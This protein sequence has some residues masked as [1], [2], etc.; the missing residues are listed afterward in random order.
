M[1]DTTPIRDLFVSDVTRDIPPVVYFHEQSPEKLAAEVGE[2]IITGGWPEDHPNHRRVPEG[3]HEQYVRL[4]N[5]IAAELDRP[6]GPDLPTIWISGFFGSGKSIFSKLLGLALDGIPLP[7]GTS[8]AEAWLRRDTSPRASELRDAWTALRRKIDPIAVVFDVGSVA[9]DNEQVHSVAVRQVQRRLGYCPTE[10][11]VADFELTLERDGHWTRF[12]QVAQETLGEPW[13]QIK[14]RDFAEEDFSL[15]MSRLFPDYY[16]DPMAWFTSRAGT[17]LRNESPEEAVR[18]ISDM[19]RLRRPNATLFLVV[20]EVSQ[21]V[22]SSKDR[23]DRLRAFATALGAGLKGRVW[24]LAL[25]QQ[26]LDE[27]ADQSFLIW[28]KDRF[29]PKLRVHLA[30]TN[31]RDVVHKRLLHKTPAAEAELRARFE[32]HRT[33]LKLFAYGCESVTIEDL[34]EVYPLLPGHIDLL[35]QITSAMR[36]RSRRVQGDDQA[37]RGLLQMLGELFRAQR[38]ADL[39]VGH[40]ISL[41]RIYEVQHSALDSDIQASMA[42]ILNQCAEEDGLLIR[43]AK[44]VALLELIQDVL[45]TDAKLVSQCLYDRLDRGNQVTEITEALETLRRRNLLGYSEKT[46]YKIQSSAGEEWERERADIPVPRETIGDGIKQALEILLA[47]PHQPRLQGRPFPWAGLLSDGRSH[48][49]SRFGDQ[50]SDAVIQ[51]DFRFI[52]TEERAESLWVKRSA[53]S[54][55]E[56]RILWVCGDTD[57]LWNQVRE[58]ARSRGMLSKFTPRRES[59]NAARKILLEQEKV[60]EE[61]LASSVQARVAATWM[62]GHLYFR[63]RSL[64]PGDLGGGFASALEAVGTRLL[65]ELYPHFV[66][67]DLQPGELLHLLETD[68]TGPSPKLMTGELG[69]LE[70]DHGRYEP[71]CGGAVPKRVQDFIEAEGGLGGTALLTHFGRPPYGYT[72]NVVK[73]CV[74]GLLRGNKLRIQPE[75]TPE[76]TAVRDA[77]VRDLFEKDRS[78]RRANVFPSGEDD[79]GYPVRARICK[80]FEKHLRTEVN[81]SDDAIAD[82]VANLFPGQAQRL[83][84][85]LTQLI[86]LPDGKDPPAALTRLQDAL[87]DCTRQVRQTRPTVQQVKRHIDALTDGIEL[88]NLYSAEL[89]DDAVSRVTDAARVRDYQAS[90]LH[91]VGALDSALEAARD[92]V[93]THLAGERPWRD[94][95]V[96]EPDLTAIRAAYSAERERRLARQEQQAEQA[97]GR[98]RARNGFATLTAD[99][100]HAVLRPIALAVTDTTANAVAPALHDLEAPFQIRLEQAEDS[101][102][103]ILDSILSAGRR[104]LIVKMDLSLRNREIATEADVD[105]LLEEI[106]KRLLEQLDAG[107]RVRIL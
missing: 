3:I 107:V 23:V 38:L 27:D 89:S 26:K 74:A 28:A 43:A 60:R 48:G 101:A 90:Q 58:L 21:Y 25:G 68:L 93:E 91:A 8:L 70:L 2:Y 73:A 41:D 44:T 66:V 77:G 88:V 16:T 9:R 78:F 31:I 35:L 71:T 34:I 79:I 1:K 92:R 84:A 95:T 104:P 40:L 99:Q 94:I 5:A 102:D 67:T 81:R 39:P 30:A 82:A 56:N 47:A 62:T 55:L 7:D 96:L 36:S 4:L 10:P 15:V 85:V 69:I 50:R 12:E 54:T 6:G 49:D 22:L 46:G 14:G 42:R 63:G 32:A 64:N 52:P 45:P 33:D 75:G 18:A 103:D 86:R 19:L 72:A 83:R 106:R 11:L 37:I 100:S 97:R 57:A 76:I 29:P 13:E 59:L 20:D 17:H 24:L 51:V 53:E 61:D 98:I 80:F 105:S 87:E 65:P